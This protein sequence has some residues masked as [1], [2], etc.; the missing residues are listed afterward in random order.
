MN[1]NID[2]T[3]EVIVKKKRGRPRKY[4]KEDTVNKVKKKRG[5]PKGIK[6][7]IKKTPLTTRARGRPKNKDTVNKVYNSTKNTTKIESQN[8]IIHLPIKS[9]D[10]QKQKQNLFNYNPKL[11]IPKAFNDDE[12][13][14]FSNVLDNTSYNTSTQKKT[15]EV[16]DTN[17]KNDNNKSRTTQEHTNEDTNE[18]TNEYTNKITNED[19]NEITNDPNN[20]DNNSNDKDSS[21]YVDSDNTVENYYS[22][23]NYNLIHKNNWYK[24]KNDV[25]T[26]DYIKDL[27]QYKKKRDRN[28]HLFSKKT[29]KHTDHILKEFDTDVWP[30]ETSVYCWW[31]CHPFNCIPCSIPEKVEN[32]TFIVHG[33]FCSPE[34]AAAYLFN[35]RNHSSSKDIWIRYPLLNLLYKDIYKGKKIEQA[36]SREVLQIFGGPLTINEFRNITN[37]SL[38]N[39]TLPKMKSIIPTISHSSIHTSYSSDKYMINEDEEKTFSNNEPNIEVVDTSVKNDT[40][41][42]LKRSKPFRKYDNTLE[43]CMNLTLNKKQ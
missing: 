31:C 16:I 41:L 43:K 11:S 28:I 25:K 8:I 38:Y 23:Y 21:N 15:I 29:H 17:S 7:K 34:C 37:K 10:I 18:I 22:N 33:I 36:F 24:N 35:D 13:S 32:N 39:V 42:V 30:T 5:R 19:T 27:I 6:N 4:P 20:I 2:N 9:E 26:S 3:Q 14:S 1:I 40:T 12:F